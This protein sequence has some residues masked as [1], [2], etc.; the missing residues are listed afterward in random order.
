MSPAPNEKSVVVPARQQYSHSAS[1][2]RRMT[3]SS[4]ISFRLRISWVA[5]RQNSLASSQLTISTELRGPCHLLDDRF[6]SLPPVACS[7]VYRAAGE[8]GD[9][10]TEV[11]GCRSRP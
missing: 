6:I 2:G 1:L 3:S 5:R 8:R 4:A 7:S 10:Q 11:V 9:A